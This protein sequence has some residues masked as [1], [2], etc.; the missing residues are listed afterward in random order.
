M[1]KYF[2]LIELLVVIAII[3][4]LA[5]MLLPSL[6]KARD[7]AREIECVN[8][9]KQHG[10]A[11]MLYA[12]DY[13]DYIPPQYAYGCPTND[14]A[15][16]EFSHAKNASLIFDL[17][18]PYSGNT[19]LALCP[20]D[21]YAPANIPKNYFKPWSYVRSMTSGYT[22]SK[23]SRYFK[24]STLKSMHGGRVILL[25][26]GAPNTIYSGDGYSA[27]SSSRNPWLVNP[28]AANSIP[29]EA[30]PVLRH[31]SG[32]RSTFAMSDGSAI[33]LSHVEFGPIHL[34]QIDTKNAR[35]S[36]QL[37]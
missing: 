16:K 9:Q 12:N 2:T 11:M 30:L 3:A 32:L 31:G 8:Q 17:L 6:N 35:S 15:N 19:R 34:W 22:N 18:H 1:K 4:I 20:S 25:S 10:T 36:E 21:Q 24:R 27:A 14:P 26:C 33:A 23:R 5:S 28:F 29:W 7:K 37:P 13:E